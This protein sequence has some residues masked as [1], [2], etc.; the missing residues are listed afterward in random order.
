MAY[1]VRQTCLKFSLLGAFLL[2]LQPAF[3]QPNFDDLDALLTR[4][5]KLLG[6]NVIALIY[7]DGKIIHTK[8]IGQDF[9]P[10]V[11]APIANAGQWITAALIMSLVDEGKISLDD[12]VM[13]YIP[14]FGPYSKKYITI[15]NCLTHTTGIQ[16][17]HSLLPHKKSGTLEDEATSFAKKEIDRNPG[18]TFVFSN[19]GFNI[20]GRIAEIV[21]KKTFD[22]LVQ[23]RIIRP[24]KMRQTTFYLDYDKAI[25]PSGGA[26][27]SANDYLNFLVM[28]LNKG[29]F[30]GKRILSEKSVDEMEKM[31]TGQAAIKFMPKMGEG[32][33]YG[34]GAW[35]LDKDA[36]GKATVLA[37][38][39]L[40]GTFPYID[41]CRGYACIIF[42]KTLLP[43]QKKELYLSIKDAI[44]QQIPGTCK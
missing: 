37:S 27:S 24:L 7:K 32:Y 18:E 15:R 1:K 40:F 9:T 22:R 12:P 36:S 43:E 35:I 23:D 31:Q 14:I 21:T 44:D 38:P 4:N 16:A 33:D 29:T 17:D 8:Q 11:Q 13:K 26:Y 30:E 41:Y 10:K 19:I 39:S 6:G 42:T 34:F 28:M 3:S 20:A 5:E 25:D 2:L